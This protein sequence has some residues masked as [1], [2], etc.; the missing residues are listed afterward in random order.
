MPIKSP[1]TNS[2]EIKQLYSFNVYIGK[3]D[4]GVWK[5]EKFN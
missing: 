4:T 5:G 3:G 2:L 1:E